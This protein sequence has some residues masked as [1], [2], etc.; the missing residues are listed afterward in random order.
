MKL[1]WIFA[2][3]AVIFFG[4]TKAHEDSDDPD[5]THDEGKNFDCETLVYTWPSHAFFSHWQ[6]IRTKE[7]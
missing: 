2:L 1:R 6:S 4:L 3:T 5:H 7:F